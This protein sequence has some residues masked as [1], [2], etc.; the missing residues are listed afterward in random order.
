MWGPRYEH[1]LQQN[2]IV[3]VYEDDFAGV[4]EGDGW[5]AGGAAGKGSALKEVQTFTDLTRS[6]GR[7]VSAVHWHPTRKVCG[8]GCESFL[9]LMRCKALSCG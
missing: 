7:A 6:K 4:G 2:D 8:S 5:E 1:A 9:L 3:N